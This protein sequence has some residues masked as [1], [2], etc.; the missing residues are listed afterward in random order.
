[1]FDAEAKVAVVARLEVKGL[2][3]VDVSEVALGVAE[4]VEHVP[5]KP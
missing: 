4:G 5:D 2:G 1:V 3:V